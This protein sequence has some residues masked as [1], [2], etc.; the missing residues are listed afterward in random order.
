M[1]YRQAFK[2][3]MGL[4]SRW[5][6]IKII[7]QTFCENTTVHGLSFAM[8]LKVNVTKTLWFT[9]VFAAFLGLSFHLYNISDAYFQYRTAEYSYEKYDGYYF[10]DVTI[11]NNNG[12]S[13]SSLIEVAKS[14][15]EIKCLFDNTTNR[16]SL[17]PV[18][19][20]WALG[21]D[22][23]KLGHTFNN[24]ILKCLFHGKECNEHDFELF[25]PPKFF[26]CYIFKG[27]RSQKTKAQTIS[28]GLSL[29]IYLE[30]HGEFLYQSYNPYTP[31]ANA[32]G[33][34]VGLAPP[35]GYT[36]MIADGFDILAGLSTSVGFKVQE[37]NR[38]GKPYNICSKL[39]NSKRPTAKSDRYSYM[40]CKNMCIHDEVIDNCGCFPMVYATR[41]KYSRQNISS[42][43]NFI[44]V[45]ET[46]SNEL[47]Q[48]QNKSLYKKDSYFAAMC[49][50][51]VP[52]EDMSYTVTLSQSDWPSQS[53]IGSFL[54]V[55]VE[56]N[57][58]TKAY[59]YYQNLLKQ[60]A[61]KEVKHKWVKSS[62][63]RLNVFAKSNVVVM[64]DQMPFVSRVDLLCQIGGCLGL[65]L[66]IS[67]VTCAEL[68]H[69]IGN[70]L[71]A[72]CETFYPK[73]SQ[74]KVAEA[75]KHL[76]VH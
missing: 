5:Q 46:L 71:I 14:H 54:E 49:D 62:F 24:M 2:T 13:S 60:N 59:S 74:I 18:D 44:F 31:V 34:R 75:P 68:F 8:G 20:F 64:Y 35:N 19:L 51:H 48:C 22:A 32:D 76:R 40:E 27:G 26:N 12:I 1:H 58:N 73:R 25:H 3:A 63:L 42:C 52:C 43:G 7:L 21:D 38:L 45:N 37:K 56:G 55:L 15:P 41:R 69:L 66:G 50:C 16:C 30:P 53:V 11:C 6:N 10:P 9:I 29:T 33:I 67:V 23:Y 4:T 36:A 61:S 39:K 72:L 57:T 28:N 70:L 47:I 17:G 65:W